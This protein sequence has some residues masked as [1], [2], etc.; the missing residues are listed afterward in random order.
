VAT[1]T[2]NLSEDALV[3]M[4]RT[5]PEDV[6]GELFWKVMVDYDVSPLDSDEEKAL[7]K[8]MSDAEREETV[9]WEDIR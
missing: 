4:L 1:K 5:L 2:V 3:A 8:A 9:D 6:L 7:E